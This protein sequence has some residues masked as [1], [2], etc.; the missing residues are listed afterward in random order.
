MKVVQL[1]PE[2]NEGGVERG[3]VDLNREFIKKGIDNIVIS[4]GGRLVDDILKN[5]GKHIQF[6]IKSKNIFTVF[7]RIIKLKKILKEL[8]PDILHVRSRVP[9]WLVY[10]ANKSLKIKV[11]STVHGFNSISFYSKIM[12]NADKIICGSQFMIE[13]IIKNYN[14]NRNKIYLISRG[15]DEEYFN[16]LNFD[17]KFIQGI[18]DKHNLK[19]SI[20]LSQIAR[21]THWKDQETTIKAISLLKKEYPNIKLLL[22]GSYSAD[23]ESYY[24]SLLKL[25]K[26]NALTNDVIFIGFT[27]K[28]K[29]ILSISD[30]N[31]SSSFKPETFGRANVEGMFLGVPLIAT[32]IGAT[33]DYIIEG[34][35]GFFF[36]PK[37]SKDLSKTIVKVL[38][39]SFEK[40]FIINFAKKN[41]T[42][43]A[44]VNKNLDIYQNLMENK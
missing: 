3:V 33:S 44:M 21:I 4:N 20:I 26:E 5:G 31:I 40:E 7:S 24:S 13:H 8:N 6:D 12:T 36:N 19:N 18:I 9:A 42:L 38:N 29:E 32:N 14:T 1:L 30:I 2:L 28:I 41:F 15:I 23:R 17:D 39:S 34:K 27:D 37:D 22:V 25:V 16:S 35:T 43:N 11:V 10:F